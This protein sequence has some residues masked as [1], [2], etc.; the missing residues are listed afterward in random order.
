MFGVVQRNAAMKSY[1]EKTLNSTVNIN[2]AIS[3]EIGKKK[4]YRTD[5]LI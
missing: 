2:G 5:H 4:L 1:M 3:Y